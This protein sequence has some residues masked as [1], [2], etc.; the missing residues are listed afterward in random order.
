[1]DQPKEIGRDFPVEDA[2]VIEAKRKYLETKTASVLAAFIMLTVVA[3]LFAAFVYGFLYDSFSALHTIWSIVA[4]PA[5]AVI[6]HYFERRTRHE[7]ENNTS[8]T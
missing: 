7:Q 1:M 6:T 8:S 5:G 3:T 4:L 2:A